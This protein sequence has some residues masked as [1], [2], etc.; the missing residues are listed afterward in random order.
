MKVRLHGQTGGLT[1]LAVAAEVELSEEELSSVKD[2]S[3]VFES[4]VKTNSCVSGTS[5]VS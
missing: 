3:N 1:S 5:C 4:W 2:S